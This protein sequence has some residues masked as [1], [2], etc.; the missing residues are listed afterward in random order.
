MD[1][2]YVGAGAYLIGVPARDLSVAEL[3]ALDLDAGVLVASGLYEPV[4]ELPAEE[5]D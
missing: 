4:T 3:V 5:R 1:L 2:R